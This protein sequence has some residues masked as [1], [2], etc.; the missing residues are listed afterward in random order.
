MAGARKLTIEILGNAKDAAKAFGDVRSDSE[1]TQERLS[2]FGTAALGVGVA[3]AGGL[4]YAVTQLMISQT[5][6]AWPSSS[7][8]ASTAPVA[9]ALVKPLAC[10][11]PP[12]HTAWAIGA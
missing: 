2:N 11:Q 3:I 6:A 4:A 7:S 5:L 12:P 9:W 10:S 1:K 8:A